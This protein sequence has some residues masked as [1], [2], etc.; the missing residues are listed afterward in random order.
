LLFRRVAGPTIKLERFTVPITGGISP[1][2]HPGFVEVS[3]Q[4]AFDDGGGKVEG[5]ALDL[6]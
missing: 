1:D 5:A 2:P 6:E 4:A 3:D